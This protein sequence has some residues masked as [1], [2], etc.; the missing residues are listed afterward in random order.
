MKFNW[1]EFLNQD[2][3]IAVH[4]KTEEEAKDFCR[5]MEEHGLK[6]VD[7]DSYSE[8]YYHMFKSETCYNNKGK[9][10]SRVE[11]LRQSFKIYEWSDFMKNE[12]TKSDLENGDVIVRRDGSVEI[13]CTE[14]GT[15][16]T[17]DGYNLLSD[18]REDLTDKYECDY[19]IMKVYRPQHPSQCQ[20]CGCYKGGELVY[21]RDTI[22]KE[23]SERCKEIEELEK[24]I[25]R[26]C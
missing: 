13:V 1:D 4:C 12:F 10:S 21:D 26:D 15:L 9:I 22:E 7:G 16:I 6:W 11:Y 8:C 3:K 25:Q 17:E 2:N 14:T 23:R 20:F 19:D 18:V 24:I 5:K